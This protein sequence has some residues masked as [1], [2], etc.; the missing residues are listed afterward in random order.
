MIVLDD[1]LDEH[2]VL[3]PIKKWAKGKIVFL[4]ELKPGSVIKDEAVPK[5]LARQRRPTFITANIADFWLK[6]PAHSRYCIICFPLPS[7]RQPEIPGLLRRLLQ[8]PEFR[9]QRARM[10]RV[11]RVSN[12]GIQHYQIGRRIVRIRPWVEA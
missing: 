4:R 6:V 10:G 9:T 8:I 5:L 3:Q 12:M 2:D 11:I 1:S 7:P